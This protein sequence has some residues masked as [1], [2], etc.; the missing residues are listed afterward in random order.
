MFKIECHEWTG[1]QVLN[2]DN[3]DDLKDVDL[4]RVRSSSL[5]ALA[6]FRAGRDASL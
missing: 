2:N 3:A 5:P 1:G 6:R 4:N